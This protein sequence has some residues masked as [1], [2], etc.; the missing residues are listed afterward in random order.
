MMRTELR[1]RFWSFVLLCL[2]GVLCAS[3]QVRAEPGDRAMSLVL[4]YGALFAPDQISPVS[5]QFRNRTAQ[6]VVGEVRMPLGQEPAQMELRVPITVPAQSRVKAT[7]WPY[8]TAPPETGKPKDR[9][10]PLSLAGWYDENHARIDRTELLGQALSVDIAADPSGVP[11]TGV[12]LSITGESADTADTALLDNVEDLYASL[13]GVHYTHATLSPNLAPRQWVGLSSCR[14]VALRGFNPNELDYAQRTALL[15]FVRGGG[16]LLISAPR[17]AEQV[18]ESWLKGY[19]PVRLIGEREARQIQQPSGPMKL[20]D[21]Q[22]CSEA[23]EGDGVVTLRDGDYVHAAWRALGL[24]RVAYTSFPAGSLE[25][26]DPRTKALWR[27]LLAM[28]RLH[29]G[30]GG[31][32]LQRDYGRL[33][34]PMLGKPTAPW[35]MAALTIGLYAAIVLG[36]QLIWRGP[37]RPRA[38]AVSLAIGVVVAGVFVAITSLKRQGLSLQSARLT[39]ADIGASG[40][41]KI[42]ELAAF[43]GQD[44]REMTLAGADQDVVFRPAYNRSVP[45]LLYERPWVAPEAG[46]TAERISR[47]WNA[48]SVV[49]ASWSVPAVAKFGPDGLTLRARNQT[50]VQLDDAQLVWRHERFAVGKINDQER[51]VALTEANHR[52]P[53][54]Y[55]TSGGIT[56][57][58]ERLKGDIL[59]SVLNLSDPTLRA[60]EI[61]APSLVAW[62]T[63]VPELLRAGDE[64]ARRGQQSL[65]RVPVLVE[66]PKR[67]E[68]VRI[69]PWF[70]SLVTAGLRGLP[71]DA[72]R[73]EWLQS[74]MDGAWTFAIAAPPQVGRL[75]PQKVRFEIDIA[76][77]QHRVVIRRGQGRGGK[78]GAENPAGPIVGQWDGPLGRKIAEFT[79]ESAD[80]DAE[81]RVW[82]LLQAEATGAGSLGVPPNWRIQSLGASIEGQV[83]EPPATNVPGVLR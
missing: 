60:A 56:S 54:E 44:H 2:V 12:L 26:A 3:G 67:G 71:Y 7:A 23:V 50:P 55:T 61:D 20:G 5:M 40:G 41:G 48:R 1:R 72:S 70:C 80:F 79:C 45:V 81:G 65:V 4:Q 39:V 37:R 11:S 83:Q 9:K 21:W 35:S 30:I 33:L 51:A 49:P 66:P 6:P 24:G 62:A 53:N 68:I 46:V 28:D 74:N 73:C 27:D 31:T 43:G 32:P 47:V 57:Q 52:P 8:L 69:D 77:P 25:V 64:I 17:A 38:F 59:A 63:G 78:D 19:M 42:E 10:P 34:E 76:A 14:V 58:D 18:G 29:T 82:F 13:K 15:D 22:H 75:V 36:V 16:V